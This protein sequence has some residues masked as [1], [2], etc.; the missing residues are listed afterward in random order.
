[1]SSPFSASA[2]S[3]QP[4]ASIHV[5]RYNDPAR[6]ALIRRLSGGRRCA[7]MAKKTSKLPARALREH[8]VRYVVG[9]QGQAVSVLLTLE[10]YE[11][12]LDLLDDEA[13]SHD[14]SL[15]A[16]LAQT[17]ARPRRHAGQLAPRSQ[18]LPGPGIR[19]DDEA[20]G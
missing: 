17:A 3:A 14:A 9:A 8:A 1:M 13:D 4:L 16:R 6:Y 7:S 10:E 19:Q 11:H 2:I 12:Y 15:A 5:I 20:G 18:R